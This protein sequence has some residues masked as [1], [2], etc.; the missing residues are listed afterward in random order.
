MKLKKIIIFYPSFERGGV[1]INL[2]NLINYFSKK[3]IKIDLISNNVHKNEKLKNLKNINFY[4]INFKNIFINKRLSLAIKATIQLLKLIKINNHNDTIIFSLQSSMLP[5]LVSK[6]SKMKIVAR[7]ASDP[8]SSTIYAE[9]K[10]YSSIIFLLRFFIY[11][12]ANGIITNSKGSAKSLEFFVFNKKKIKAIYNPY[13]KKIID[14]KNVKKNKQVLSIGRFC[15]QKNFKFLINVFE[16]FIVKNPDYKL[17]IVGDGNYKT[18]LKNLIKTKKLSNKVL[19][20]G[21]VKD[22]SKFFTKSK[23]F[24]LPSLYEGL[25]NVVIDSLNYSVPVICTNCKS[26]P[27]EIIMGKKGGYLVNVNNENQM[28]YSINYSINN[29]KKSIKK[30]KYARKYLYRFL[31]EKNSEKYLNFLNKQLTN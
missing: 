3:N 12:L 9:N 17:V 30:T 18:K 19:L 8:I 13:V 21:W 6:F 2:I 10:I 29:Y 4:P 16:K 26:G 1:E 5:I 11:N 27:N 14:F 24:V 23:I 20:K 7:N 25:G 28:L 22:T 15:K 31:I